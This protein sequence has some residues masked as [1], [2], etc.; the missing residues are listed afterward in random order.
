VALRSQAVSQRTYP[1]LPIMGMPSHVLSG[2]PIVSP[3]KGIHSKGAFARLL[4]DR[5][6]ATPLAARP[7]GTRSQAARVMV[8]VE[9]ALTAGSSGVLYSSQ[10]FLGAA[11]Q[12]VILRLLAVGCLIGGM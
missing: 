4:Q 6:A 5:S 2:A 11:V 3:I 7:Q 8:A 12:P 1:L 9:V 10:G